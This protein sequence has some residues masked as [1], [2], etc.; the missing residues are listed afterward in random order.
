MRRREFTTYDSGEEPI[1]CINCGEDF[2][3]SSG[4][5]C[6]HCDHDHTPN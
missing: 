5:I 3:V 4:P 6:P 2:A 1:S